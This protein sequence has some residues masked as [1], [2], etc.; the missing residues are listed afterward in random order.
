MLLPE[1]TQIDWWTR[2]PAETWLLLVKLLR[3]RVFAVAKVSINYILS[4]LMA[5][6]GITSKV[7]QLS[8]LAENMVLGYLSCSCQV[9]LMSTRSEVEEEFLHW[10][11]EGG[12]GNINCVLMASELLENLVQCV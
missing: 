9:D 11:V 5:T 12:Q 10:D 6:C 8:D 7:I 2:A 1:E 4:S 3:A